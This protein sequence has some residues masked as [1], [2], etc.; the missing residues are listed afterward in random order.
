V[1]IV[2]HG[3]SLANTAFLEGLAEAGLKVKAV[4]AGTGDEEVVASPEDSVIATDISLASG[5]ERMVVVFL[6]ESLKFGW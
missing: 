1:L 5:L 4:E 6:P 2:T 3:S